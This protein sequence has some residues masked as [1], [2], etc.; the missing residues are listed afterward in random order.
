[1][2]VEAELTPGV[3]AGDVVRRML[4]NADVAYIHAHYATRG[5]FAAMIERA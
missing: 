3:E 2:M 1:M 5:C 4:A